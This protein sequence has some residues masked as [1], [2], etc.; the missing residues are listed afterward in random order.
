LKSL[1]K[2]KHIVKYQYRVCTCLHLNP[3]YVCQCICDG[4]NIYFNIKKNKKITSV[5]HTKKKL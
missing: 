3:R 2:E 4:E 1:I 5:K